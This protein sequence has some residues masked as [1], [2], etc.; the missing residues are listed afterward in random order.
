MA[1][2]TMSSPLQRPHRRHKRL[3]T[4]PPAGYRRLPPGVAQS[5]H[6][7]KASI[8]TTVGPSS[9]AT[10]GNASIGADSPET[11]T[12]WPVLDRPSRSRKGSSYAS[13]VLRACRRPSLTRSHPPRSLDPPN[14]L[15]SS[16]S[17]SSPGL[18]RIGGWLDCAQT[19]L[20][21]FRGPRTAVL[22]F[23]ACMPCRLWS[24]A[25]VFGALP[26]GRGLT[27]ARTRVLSQR[28]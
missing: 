2:T 25:C 5:I 27:G 14:T 16:T 3:F 22:P 12:G 28:Q 6:S 1:T 18:L 17:A 4:S 9:D 10:P 23:Q 19:S 24:V 26:H 21:S 8:L 15:S 20:H 11:G 7:A 13:P